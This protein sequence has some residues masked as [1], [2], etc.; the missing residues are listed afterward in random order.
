MENI[1]KSF[2]CFKLFLQRQDFKTVSFQSLS[3][4]NSWLFLFTPCI[5]T[6][7]LWII[8]YLFEELLYHVIG[9]TGVSLQYT[10]VYFIYFQFPTYLYSAHSII[11]TVNYI[12]V[13]FFLSLIFFFL[14]STSYMY[15]FSHRFLRYTL[16]LILSSSIHTPLFFL[17]TPSKKRG[18]PL[19]QNVCWI[20][21]HFSRSHPP[22]STAASTSFI[23]F[24]FPPLFFISS[25]LG[26]WVAASSSYTAVIN[27]QTRDAVKRP[28]KRAS[29]RGKIK[30]KLM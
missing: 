18:L 27:Y 4:K 21:N 20:H 23:F 11:S 7:Y 17:A 22:H 16:Y 6:N 19:E 26:S 30:E 9:F 5:F 28:R 10:H 15:K 2:V 1:T 3:V 24:L 12:S 8:L 14:F 29:Q 25:P 13:P